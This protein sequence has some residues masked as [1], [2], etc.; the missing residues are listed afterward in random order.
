[1][2]TGWRWTQGFS[3]TSATSRNGTTIR[4]RYGDVEVA[5]VHLHALQCDTD[6]NLVT[7]DTDD[8]ETEGEEGRA[9]DQRTAREIQGDGGTDQGDD[10]QAGH[11]HLVEIG[12]ICREQA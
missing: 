9:E 4:V 7:G 3:V 5:S 8:D 12:E 2:V 10:P 6:A 1:M 11:D